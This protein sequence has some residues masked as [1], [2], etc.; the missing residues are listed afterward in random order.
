[1]GGK[2]LSVESIR[3]P[4]PRYFSLEKQAIQVLR[5]AFPS[6][7]IEPI[8]AISNKPDFGDMDLLI[9][10][11]P[12]C[13]L[14]SV[15]Q[16]LSPTEIVRNGNVMSIGI[17]VDEGLFQV[18][19]IETLTTNF[20]FSARYFGFND[21]GNLIGR[22]A[23]KFGAKFGHQGLLYPIRDPE[24]GS[25]LVA[26]VL[27]TTEF[28][29]ALEL[30]GYNPTR[31]E[32]M[33][34]DNAFQTL[35]DVF[36]YVTSSPYINPEI[37][38]LNNRNSIAR[39]RE[40]KRP[41]YNA[42]LSWLE[43]QPTGSIPAY[44]WGKT[45]SDERLMQCRAFL[46]RACIHVPDFKMRYDQVMANFSRKKNVKIRFNGNRVHNLTGATGKELGKLM[47]EIQTSFGSEFDL[48]TFFLNA[49]DMEM[50]RYIL[51]VFNK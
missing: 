31:Y 4:A 37:Y 6:R 9:E 11:D 33:R 18:D 3:L 2:A 30:I 46:E 34:T 39:A 28:G 49:S 20:D 25:H 48:E 41:T 26:E 8:M 13:D 36:R 27:I 43:M 38:L 42:F 7:R 44:A 22:V 10:A 17:A 50:D 51:S 24:N 12:N 19:L 45:G 5:E 35:G 47:S 21:F 32:Q 14:I 29:T 1:M 40:M 15:A 23:H 16:V